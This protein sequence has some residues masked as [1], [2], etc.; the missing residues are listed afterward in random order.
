MQCGKGGIFPATISWPTCV[1]NTTLTT[2]APPNG[3]NGGG[4]GGGGECNCVGD[5]LSGGGD[6]FDKNKTKDI[7]DDL[8]RDY[9]I[10]GN[11]IVV[12]SMT[13]ASDVR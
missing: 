10:E 9:S 5:K 7:I 11:N 12:G 13:P 4:A 6:V 1:D 3:P 2:P 8:C